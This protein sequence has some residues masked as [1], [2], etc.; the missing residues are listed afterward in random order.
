MDSFDKELNI[1]SKYA[2][3]YNELAL[4]KL[5]FYV[6]ENEDNYSLVNKYYNECLHD[7][8]KRED[9]INL[10]QKKVLEVEELPEKGESVYLEDL[11]FRPKFM[12]NFYKESH[13]LGKE[14]WEEFPFYLVTSRQNYPIKNFSKRFRD[15]DE[16]F[17]F[18][19]KAIRHDLDTHKL[20]IKS[21]KF[22]KEN[23][24]ISCNIVDYLIGHQWTEHIK[25]MNG[26]VKDI[27]LRFDPTELI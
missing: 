2:L 3:S 21:L 18:Y 11:T 14:L 17:S 20:V 15:L 7:S 13:V 25:M 9:L 5:I 19:G 6:K 16:L 8:L 27:S 4:I 26:E 24:L 23:N 1:M 22:A 10:Q 12:A